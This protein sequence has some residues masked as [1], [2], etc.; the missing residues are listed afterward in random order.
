MT[1][2]YFVDTNVFVY[3]RD[4]GESAKQARAAAWIEHLWQTRLG[5]IS[6]QVLQ[7]YYQVVTQRLTPGLHPES[8]RHDVRDLLAWQPVT[9]DAAVLE[10][11]WTVQDRYSCS[12]WDALIIGAAQRAGCEFLLTEDLQPGQDLGGLQVVNPFEA[13]PDHVLQ[14]HDRT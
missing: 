11:A 1:G 5:R 13:E 9:V 10:K 3:A 14:I 6:Y 8:A 7:E 4:A 2:T 12:W